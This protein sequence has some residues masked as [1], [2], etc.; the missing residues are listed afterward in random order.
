MLGVWL[1]D[2]NNSSRKR[3][4]FEFFVES[5]GESGQSGES[6]DS[7]QSSQSRLEQVFVFYIE[8]VIDLLE[9]DYNINVEDV[10]VDELDYVNEL[11]KGLI[12]V[13][14]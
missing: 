1:F 8:E 14:E 5:S 2:G 6:S 12:E 7:S 11:E 10:D 13:E 4:D 3:K 9:W